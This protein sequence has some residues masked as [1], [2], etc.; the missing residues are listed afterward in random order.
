M[1]DLDA[2]DRAIA[3]L[4]AQRDILGD[5]VVATALRPLEQRR[6]ALSAEHAGGE[7][8]LVTV[9]FAD[10]V[11]F[12]VMSAGTYPKVV[13]GGRAGYDPVVATVTIKRRGTTTHD[14]ATRRDWAASSSGASIAGF[15][16]PNF[17]P[18]GCGP[19]GAIDL[20]YATGWGST[21]DDDPT[22]TTYTVTPKSVVVALPRAIDVGQFGVDPTA[23]C[24]DAGSASTKDYRIETSTNGTTWTVANTGTFTA[25]NRE[26]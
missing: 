12:T 1:E 7:R 13:A 15:T 18:Y 23:T 16:G 17:T 11:D 20:S 9:L 19:G 24:G 21:S 22:D 10:L 3:A 26:G 6:A 2:I 8:R 14:F 5:E 4:E 25:A